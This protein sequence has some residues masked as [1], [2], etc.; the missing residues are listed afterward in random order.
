MKTQYLGDS[1]DSF[2]WDYHDFLITSL[3]YRVLEIFPMLTPNDNSNEGNTK[4]DIYPARKQILTFC[5]DINEKKNIHIIKRLPE[6]TNNQYV[7]KLNNPKMFFAK[8]NREQYW[9]NITKDRAIIFLDPDNG[10]QPKKSLNEKH[11]S[12]A[13][14]DRLLTEIANDSVI[15]I[16]HHFRR[17]N[18]KTDFNNIL[19]SLP[20]CHAT[21]IY[22]QHVMFVLLSK[23]D[24]MIKKI[25]K[26]NISY[27]MQFPT[28]TILSRKNNHS[29]SET[30][31][32]FIEK[33]ECL[34]CKHD[35]STSLPR[36]C[37][38]CKTELK[39][40]GWG[41]MDA[42][43]R[44]NHENI[45]TYE[46]FKNSLCDFHA[47]NKRKK[48]IPKPIIN[49]EPLFEDFKDE[50]YKQNHKFALACSGNNQKFKHLLNDTPFDHSFPY[51]VKK[52]LESELNHLKIH[53][54]EN[55]HQ[56]LMRL[57]QENKITD[58]AKNLGLF[59]LG[60]RNY[61]AHEEV[62]EKTYKSRIM[63]VLHSAAILW[64]QLPQ[65]TT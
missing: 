50:F 33:D 58:D 57:N 30:K 3:K 65:Q 36:I 12:F 49:R 61:I 48:K 7:V 46:E 11:V 26:L 27:S 15:S 23:S 41:G 25:N 51:E 44:S 17:I 2:K 22:W 9:T 55:L 62:D 53:K 59:I 56:L 14:I 35:I 10:I 24:E 5:K 47:P 21:C 8:Q 39:G 1:K 45:M 29:N 31:K 34:C 16:F 19:L 60:Q 54:S 63:L 6:Y 37:P 13:E 38:I 4:H 32:M 20:K 43:W 28:K 40:N 18:F 64:P 52:K 42:H